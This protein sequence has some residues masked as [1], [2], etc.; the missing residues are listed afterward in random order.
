M[1]NFP[2]NAFGVLDAEQ[3]FKLVALAVSN[4]EVE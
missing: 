1:N 3:Q 2:V 4:K